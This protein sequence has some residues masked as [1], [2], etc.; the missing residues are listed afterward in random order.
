M[1]QGQC[2]EMIP[3]LAC[4]ASNKVGLMKVEKDD[5]ATVKDSVHKKRAGR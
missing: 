3:L 5:V 1:S 4:A 2:L